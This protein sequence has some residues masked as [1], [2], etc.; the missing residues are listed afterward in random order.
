LSGEVSVLHNGRALGRSQALSDG[1][2]VQIAGCEIQFKDMRAVAAKPPLPESVTRIFTRD[3]TMRLLSPENRSIL[4][5]K[6]VTA[7]LTPA[8]PP[9]ESD[10][11]RP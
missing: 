6:R 11:S 3:D 10:Q 4:E 5:A 1:D 7:R 2:L 8:Q 9:P